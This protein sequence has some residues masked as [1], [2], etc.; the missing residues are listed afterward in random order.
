MATECTIVVKHLVVA[1]KN[2]R[3][4]LEDIMVA[5]ERAQ[6]DYI[7]SLTDKEVVESESHWIATTLGA[8]NKTC[9]KMEIFVSLN[10]TEKEASAS[11]DKP[12]AGSS[13]IR[14]E[15]LKF[16]AFRGNTQD[17]KKTS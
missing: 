2:A 3:K 1:V 17:L 7:S 8:Y 11:Y 16:D 6:E 4:R 15:K 10:S 5:C 12:V 13:G 14:L 9:D